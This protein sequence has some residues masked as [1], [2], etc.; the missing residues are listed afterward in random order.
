MPLGEIIVESAGGVVRVVLRVLF[1]VGWELLI[2][3]TGYLLLK[4]FRRREPPGDVECAL[5]GIAFWVLVG[6]LAWLIG[7]GLG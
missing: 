5:V 2:R 1:E 7:R 3:G 6:L 4:P